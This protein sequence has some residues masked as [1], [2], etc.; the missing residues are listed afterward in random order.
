MVMFGRAVPDY[1][2]TPAAVERALLS[3]L[4]LAA[5]VERAAPGPDA[6]E[7]AYH[8]WA[9]LHGYVMLDLANMG[10]HTPAESDA[11]FERALDRLVAT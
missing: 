10:A 7:R 8:Y 4:Q 6:A 11:L 9:T 5:A 2:P 3:F 1:E